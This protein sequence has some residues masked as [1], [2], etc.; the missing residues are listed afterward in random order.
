MTLWQT[1][2]K[3]NMNKLTKSEAKSIISE[4][5]LKPLIEYSACVQRDLNVIFAEEPKPKRGKRAE[6]KIVEEAIPE[7]IVE[8]I[9]NALV[10][11]ESHEVVNKT[12]E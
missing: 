6:V 1:A 4:I 9:T 2:T 5:K 8:E 7:T 3:Y 11:D 10:N 12:E